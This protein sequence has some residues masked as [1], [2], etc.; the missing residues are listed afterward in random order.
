MTMTITICSSVDFSPEIIELKQELEARGWHVNIPFLTQKILDG[1]LKFE[2][3]QELKE[4]DGDIS[5][6]KRESVDM[7]QRYWN[8]IK[9]SDAILV[10]N[11]YKK[12]IPNYIGGSTLMEMGF[13][14]G[15]GKKIYLYNPIPERSERMHY[16]DEIMDMKPIII[17]GDLDRIR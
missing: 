1:K 16:I 2:E 15:H 4:K 5:I 7:I 9:D 10:L 6:R 14:Y 17:D 8:Y 3:Y 11:R 12:G 13:A